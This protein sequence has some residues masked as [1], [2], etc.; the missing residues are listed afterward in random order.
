MSSLSP[1]ALKALDDSLALICE[2][3]GKL[4]AAK[5]VDVSNLIEQLTIA[6]KSAQEVRELIA[7]ELPG[8][9]WQNREELDALLEE[10]QQIS[11]AKALEQLRSR[12]LALATELEHGS[13]VHRRAHRLSELNQLR[14]QAI[15][16]LRSQAALEGAPQNLPGP[17]ADRWIAWACGLKEPQ[18]AESLQT[19]RNG[20]AH[21]DDFVANL[22]PNMWIA[23]ALP[24]L[25][26]LPEPQKLADTAQE[27][28]SRSETNG[29]DEKPGIPDEVVHESSPAAL[30]SNTPPPND[31]ATPQTEEELERTLAQERALLANMM[32]LDGGSHTNVGQ[33]SKAE[34][35]LETN[36]TPASNSDTS[37]GAEAP[38]KRKW[39]FATTAVVLVFAVLGAVQWKSRWSHASSLPVEAAVKEKIAEPTQTNPANNGYLQ[40]SM[41]T[42]SETHTSNPM[43]QAPDQLKSQDQS[44]AP[45]PL[46]KVSPAKQANEHSRWCVAPSCGDSQKHRHGHKGRSSAQRLGRTAGLD[47][48]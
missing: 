37:T 16:E 23:G 4:T 9:S 28:P 14:D 38:R 40:A 41:S 32:G 42:N 46:P 13:I 34:T 45:K 30:E 35:F 3:T 5:S 25:E 22:E 11:D 12:L 43:T 17:Q 1:S 39:W 10:I 26:T 29:L 36:S 48:R 47:S 21:L 6:V 44:V 18:D 8:A 19:L 15:N 27:E 31:G 33:P 2:N 24:T 20:F 7:S